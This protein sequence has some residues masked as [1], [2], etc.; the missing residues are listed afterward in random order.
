MEPMGTL[1]GDIRQ[2]LIETNGALKIEDYPDIIRR[3]TELGVS[4]GSLNLMVRRIHGTINFNVLDEIKNMISLM[5]EEAGRFTNTD[6]QQIISEVRGRF[7]DDKVKSFI[8]DD[9]KSRGL[10][11]RRKGKQPEWTSF[12]N[13][14]MTDEE[15]E[16]TRMMRVEWLG[17]V[18]TTA[19]ELGDISFRNMDEAKEGMRS[20]IELPPLVQ[21]V[22]KGKGRIGAEVE[23]IIKEEADIDRRYLN[24]IYT[25]NPQVPF[26]F[27]GKAYTAPVELFRDSFESYAAFEALRKVYVNQHLHIWLKKA[28]MKEVKH[29]SSDHTLTGLL[30]FLYKIDPGFP[31]SLDGYIFQNPADIAGKVKTDPALRPALYNAIVA[32]HIGLWLGARKM[33][34]ELD[35]FHM[36]ADQLRQSQLYDDDALKKGFVQAFI[37]VVLPLEKL[38]FLASEPAAISIP[39]LEISGKVQRSLNIVLRSDGFVRAGVRLTNIVEGLTLDKDIL[40]FDSL[41][42][43][44]QHE[45][46][47]DIDPMKLQKG[48]LYDLAIEVTTPFDVLL[49]PVSV[50]PVFPQKAFLVQMV[51]YGLAV[52]AFFGVIRFVIDW[53]IRQMEGF[54][55]PLNNPGDMLLDI[56]FSDSVRF[57]WI[58]VIIPAIVFIFFLIMSVRIIKKIEKL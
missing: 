43:R 51:K 53:M 47:W 57:S 40:D 9:I 8:I 23:S 33:K 31:F 24:I 3:A 50:R 5:L 32:G 21:L 52:A 42:G 37:N 22:T 27:R 11:P 14:W 36:Q 16:D 45:I 48:T 54:S 35:Q 30:D 12:N 49:V 25:L 7:P 28:K 58:L 26:R 38:P 20:V 55:G 29:L 46:I 41:E 13:P 15:W 10:K 19:Q 4:P 18:A 44:I 6:A 17:E 34:K 1:E 56:L 39:E 2:L